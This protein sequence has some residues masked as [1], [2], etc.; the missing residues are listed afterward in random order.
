MRSIFFVLIVFSQVLLS[1]TPS[2]KKASPSESSINSEERIPSAER[3]KE[4]TPSLPTDTL[5][6]W[7]IPSEVPAFLFANIDSAMT[8]SLSAMEAQ[9]YKH[10]RDLYLDYQLF[11]GPENQNRSQA[12]F[13]LPTQEYF[14]AFDRR[15]KNPNWASDDWDYIY[16]GYAKKLKLHF[17]GRSRIVGQ[18]LIIDSLSGK[19]YVL[20]SNYDAGWQALVPAMGDDQFLLW[21]R[22]TYDGKG[23]SLITVDLKREEDSVQLKKTGQLSLLDYFPLEV[24]W[25]N[26]NTWAMKCLEYD[27]QMYPDDPQP[28]ELYFKSKRS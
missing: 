25:I 21:S 16:F 28:K 3:P 1:C 15:E 9:E 14:V 12:D 2:A 13:Y 8:W 26:R 18:G 6:H 23:F 11:E 4:N 22:A 20:N 5:W 17:A 24:I 7:E 19:Q 27:P 10:H